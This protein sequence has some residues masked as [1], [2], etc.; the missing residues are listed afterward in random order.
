[1]KLS[2]PEQHVL[3]LSGHR[4]TVRLEGKAIEVQAYRRGAT[5]MKSTILDALECA[6]RLA[7]N[8]PAQQALVASAIKAARKAGAAPVLVYAE[9]SGLAS[10]DCISVAL[11][12]PTAGIELELTPMPSNRKDDNGPFDLIGDIHGCADE[13]SDLLVLLGHAEWSEGRL[14]TVKHGEGRKLVFLGDLV[15]R[16]PKNLATLEI[17]QSCVED[18][19][20]YCVLGNHDDKLRRY[21]KGNKITISPGMRCTVAE[22]NGASE[23]TRLAILGFLETLEPHYS[24]D[25]GRLIVA[26]AGLA[27][28]HHG[29][30]GDGARSFALY[31]DTTGHVD[32]NGRLERG[33]WASAYT[34]KATIVH[35]HDI[36][37]EPRV[38]NNVYAIDTA[39]V[40]GGSLTALSYPEMIFTSVPARAAYYE[41]A[42]RK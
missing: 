10:D 4:G 36:Y 34:G 25:N 21:L 31:G 40:F 29:K 7:I 14:I 8:V 37:D 3:I 26:H 32:E 35:G 13:L 30:H 38:V 2:V 24:L 11:A 39:C 12:D 15:D 33:D 27:E 41:K 17:V 20:A 1:M 23:A 42:G 16:G 18:L 6:E 28:R 5:E 19:G 22:M 9:G